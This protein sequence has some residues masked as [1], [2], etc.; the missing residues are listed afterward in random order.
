MR[1]RVAALSLLLA[2]ACAYSEHE[3]GLS[4]DIALTHAGAPAGV[5]LDAAFVSLTAI[6]LLPCASARHSPGTPTRLGVPVVEDLRAPPT[7]R[8]LG[9]LAAPPGRY[10]G[11]R[12]TVGPADADALGL[13]DAP[14][15][16]GLSLR[17]DGRIDERELHATCASAHT[18]DV[19]IEPLEVS[20]ELRHARL[21]LSIDAARILD[22]VDVSAAPEAVGCAAAAAAARAI[23]RVDGSGA[24]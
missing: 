13:I 19:A 6:E 10:C 15:M 8:T 4:I 11:V 14:D 5:S 21:L 23:R 18:E 16:L 1:A 2:Q 22:G 24:P 7:A 20:A 9:T 12:V 17:L 3:D